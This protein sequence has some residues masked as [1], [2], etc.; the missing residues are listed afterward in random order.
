MEYG[1][2]EARPLNYKHIQE[3][4]DEDLEILFGVLDIEVTELNSDMRY[5]DLPIL[6]L[7]R[8][9]VHAADEALVNNKSAVG[10]AYNGFRLGCLI[11]DVVLPHELF[12]TF[13][14]IFDYNKPLADQWPQIFGRMYS[15]LSENESADILINRYGLELDPSGEYAH[16]LEMGAGLAFVLA[17]DGERQ[18]FIER[19]IEEFTSQIAVWE[20]NNE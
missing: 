6:T 1:P 14:S 7:A 8:N 17:E 19:E 12:M 11:S 18:W 4:I 16:L 10:A 13:D 5:E 20:G 3:Y 2:S 15:F 9:M